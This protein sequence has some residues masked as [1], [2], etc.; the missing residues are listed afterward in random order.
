[1]F[2][3][4]LLTRTPEG[5]RGTAGRGWVS[6]RKITGVIM[7]SQVEVR[8]LLQSIWL[9]QYTLVCMGV[10]PPLEGAIANISLG[11]SVLHT[12]FCMSSAKTNLT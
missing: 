5:D 9:Q 8:V 6:G 7:H 1:M 2:N 11:T 4:L 10:L 12:I 3:A